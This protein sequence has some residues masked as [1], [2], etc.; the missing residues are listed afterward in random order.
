MARQA[1]DQQQGGN[2]CAAETRQAE[3]NWINLFVFHVL[4]TIAWGFVTGSFAFVNLLAGFV[5]AY[6]ALW[7]PS[8]LWGDVKYFRR[9]WL[10][11]RLIGIFFYELAISGFTVARMVMTPGLNFRSGIIAIPLDARNDFE[12]TLFANLISLTPG[13]LSID[14]SADRRTLYVH[15]MATEDPEADKKS[16]KEA[17]EENIAEALE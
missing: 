6:I 17:F 1:K 8:R 9:L 3:A 11:L 2:P 10:I 14:V 16:M 4:L 12:I 5:L 7:L 13:T 15:A